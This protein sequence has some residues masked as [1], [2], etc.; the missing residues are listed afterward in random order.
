MTEQFSVHQYNHQLN[1]RP[2]SML[3]VTSLVLGILFLCLGP[4][5]FIPLILG[6]V[7]LSKTGARG[8]KKGM[9]LAI[10]GISLGGVGVLGTCLSAGILLPALGAAQMKAQEIISQSNL[11][12]L[13]QEAMLYAQ[14]NEDQFPA[15]DEW[16]TVLVDQGVIDEDVL[17]SPAEDGDG[18]SYI[19]LGGENTFDAGQILI[20]EDQKHYI[21]GVLV[22]FADGHVEMV[23]H[24]T[25][26]QM[27]ADQLAGQPDP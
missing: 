8:P 4:L 3:A 11:R 5:A 27:L 16:P 22:A 1:D 9:G 17:I 23:D 21:D 15:I 2:L 26:E 13:A 7:A 24:V 12:T 6:I 25:F 18:V 20:Y 10:A 19:Y 14:S